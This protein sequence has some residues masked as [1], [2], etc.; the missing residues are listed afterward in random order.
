MG[1]KNKNFYTRYKEFGCS[2]VS[3]WELLYQLLLYR[4][5]AE[6]CIDKPR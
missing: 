3:D 4:W 6:W 1:K 5:D 2:C